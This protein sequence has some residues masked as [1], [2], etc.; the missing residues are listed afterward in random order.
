M[1]FQF[2]AKAYNAFNHAQFSAEDTTA[3]FD[4]AGKQ[5][6]TLLSSFTAARSPRI[7][8]FALRFYF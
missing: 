5:I 2:R 8:Q 7:M 6:N 1:S 3:R 4:A